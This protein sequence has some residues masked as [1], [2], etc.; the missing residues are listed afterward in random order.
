LLNINLGV[1]GLKL[2]SL[3]ELL[4]VLASTDRLQVLSCLREEKEYRLSDIAQRLDSSI[5]E[6]SKHV[7][8]LREQNFV[9]KNPSNGYYA[10]TTLGKLVTKL[11]L[12]MEFLSENKEY[13]LTHNISSLPEEFI[14]RIGELQQHQ[15][16]AKA[17]LVL[18]FT[19]QV[20]SEADKFVWLMSDHSL[21]DS[22]IV[23]DIERDR[24]RSLIWRI[25]LPIGNKI[26]WQDLRSYAKNVHTRIEIGFSREIAGIA[27]NEEVDQLLLP[28]LRGSLDFNSGFISSSL[29]F[30]KWCQDLFGYVW[31][32][33]EKTII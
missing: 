18:S 11:L 13:L 31:K 25:I 22:D 9:E 12:S 14:G 30:C 29:S 4:F 20:I 24:N 5:Q 28:D 6:A 15:Y 17:G 19:Q 3:A 26:D 8:R 23:F 16:N 32:G 10:L 27:L 2:E 21:I 33:S 1:E 7:A